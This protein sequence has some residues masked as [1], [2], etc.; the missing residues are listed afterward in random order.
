[1]RKTLAAFAAAVTTLAVAGMVQAA[2]F[3]PANSRIV[4]YMG[5]IEAMDVNALHQGGGGTILLTDDGAG[6]H[7]IQVE[8]SVWNTVNH[9]G[10]SSLYTGVP[11]IDDIRVTIVNNGTTFT[12]NFTHINYI[13]T[14]QSTIGPS[15]GGI[16]HLKGN[17][18]VWVFGVPALNYP[19]TPMG[20]PAGG[21]ASQT[22]IGLTIKATYGPWITTALPLTGVTTNVISYDGVTGNAVT[23]RLTPQQVPRKVV[24][25]GGGFVT[26]DGGLPVEAHTLTIRGDNDLLSAASSLSGSVTLV[27][28]QRVD[29]G[30]AISGTIPATVYMDL[31]F[32]PEPGTMLLLVTGAVGLLVVGRSRLRK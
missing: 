15:L 10:G 26:T 7:N 2:T 31:S 16:G 17:T 23:M 14:A 28:P 32:V 27:A 21:T 25:T 18:V 29:T 20:G 4:M 6:G 22:V 3:E 11:N 24:S 13:N 19:L 1:M 9:S 8:P 5:S 12:E 30:A